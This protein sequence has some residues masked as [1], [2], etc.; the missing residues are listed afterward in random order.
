MDACTCSEE[1][2]MVSVKLYP[3]LKCLHCQVEAIPD[4]EQTQAIVTQFSELKAG[5]VFS[6]EDA[7][8]L[9]ESDPKLFYRVTGSLVEVNVIR[10]GEWPVMRYHKNIPASLLLPATTEVGWVIKRQNRKI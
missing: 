2:K 6:Y 10:N 4:N 8:V 5:P 7:V 3:W 9:T 1:R